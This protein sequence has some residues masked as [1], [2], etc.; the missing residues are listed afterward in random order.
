VEVDDDGGAAL[1]EPLGNGAP[2]APRRA[3][4]QCDAALEVMNAEC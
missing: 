1:S 2:N 3:R 4:D